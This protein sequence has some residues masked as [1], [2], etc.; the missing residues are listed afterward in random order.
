MYPA[1]TTAPSPCISL[2]PAAASASWTPAQAAASSRNEQRDDVRAEA[3][4]EYRVAWIGSSRP[5]AAVFHGSGAPRAPPACSGGPLRL[6]LGSQG[7]DR[8][9]PRG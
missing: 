9:T 8:C 3:R 6:V 5:V 7:G 4:P 2:R 1:P